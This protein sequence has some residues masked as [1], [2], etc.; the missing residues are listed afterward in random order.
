MCL[1]SNYELGAI[2]RVYSMSMAFPQCRD[3]LDRHLPGVER[4][5]VTSTSKAAEL[6]S[7]EVGAAAVCSPMCAELY[8]LSKVAE[9]IN[10]AKENVTRFL[11]LSASS[12]ST[13]TGDDKTL[14]RF[15]VDHRQPGALCDALRCYKTHGVNLSSIHTCPNR[16]SALWHYWFFVECHG[17]ASEPHVKQALEEMRPFCLDITVLGSFPNQ[18]KS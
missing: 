17:H 2:K 11:I 1:L 9:R 10:D 6:A 18:R 12:D 5:N 15:T 3:W 4:I 7:R 14:I 8:G 16:N 13:V